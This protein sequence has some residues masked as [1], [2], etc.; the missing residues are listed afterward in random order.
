MRNTKPKFAVIGAGYWGKNIVRVIK[1]HDI[2]DIECVH[3]IDPQRL[4]EISSQYSGIK[5]CF[6]I[7]Q[8]LR[9]KEI[10]GVIIAVSINKLYEVS[11]VV[12]ENGFNAFIEKPVADNIDKVYEL[13]RIADSKNII[14][15]PGFI[16]RFD[17][18][19]RFFKELID[20][21]NLHPIYIITQRSGRRGPRYKSSSIILDLGIH[22]IDLMNY[23]LNKNAQIIDALITRL[24]DDES[25]NIYLRYEN[26]IA[27]LTADPIPNIKIRRIYVNFEEGFSYEGDYVSSD[28]IMIRSG[29]EK[30]IINLQKNIEPLALELIAFRNKILGKDEETPSL[31]DAVRAHM[32]IKEIFLKSR[33]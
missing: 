8:I 25:Y 26:C 33:K 23:L 10:D 5:P 31:E 3:D 15:V 14:A 9:N 29:G 6:E 24:E 11:R 16:L 13:K 18:V 19:T 7:D 1:T 32:I 27:H 22:D 30:E 17:P 20:T 12:L 28:L 2:G 21:K 4:K